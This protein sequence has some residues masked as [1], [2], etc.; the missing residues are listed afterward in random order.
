MMRSSLPILGLALL[1]LVAM[2]ARSRADY[3]YYGV[4][5][6]VGPSSTMPPTVPPVTKYWLDQFNKAINNAPVTIVDF[7]KLSPASSPTTN[8]TFVSIGHAFEV[9][10]V[11]TDHTTPP[12]GFQYGITSTANSNGN[13]NNNLFGF[14]TSG[15]QHFEFVP[16]VGL[17]PS[18]S[19]SVTFRTTGAPFTSFGFFLTGLGDQSNVPQQP[20]KLQLTLQDKTLQSKIITGSMTGGELFV[21]YVGDGAPITSFTLTMTGFQPGKRDAFG[22]DD[23]RFLTSVPEPSSLALL[24]VSVGLCGAW[25]LVVRRRKR[26]QKSR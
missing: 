20:G 18:D 14:S 6:G 7:E 25:R 5:P 9:E 15:T 2:N 4:D 24:G 16:K 3:F 11:N 1:A 23:I 13:V 10:T 12:P 19:A 8:N 26:K 17:G 21:G 22:I